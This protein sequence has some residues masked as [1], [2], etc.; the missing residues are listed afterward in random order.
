MISITRA[1]HIFFRRFLVSIFYLAVLF[2]VATTAEAATLQLSPNTGVY[3]AGGTFSTRVIVNTQG[4]PINAAEG[5]ISFNPDDL[6]VVSVSKAGSIFTLWTREP[7]FSNTSG[8][9]SFGGGSPSGYTGAAGTVMTVTFRVKHAGTTNVTYAAGSVL[10]ADGKGTNVISNMQ[11]GSYTVQAVT[12]AP[13]PEYVPPANTPNAPVITSTTHP[14]EDKWYAVTNAKLTWSVP[15]GVTAVRTLLDD[16]KTTVPTKVYDSPIR[17]VSLPD[18]PQGVSYFHIQFK[19]A[20]GW[21]RVTHYRLAVDTEKPTA[22]SVTEAEG[23]DVARPEKKLSLNIE[24]ATSGVGKF[25]IQIDGGEKVTFD[26]SKK[27][28]VYTTPALDPGNHSVIIEGFDAAGNSII[29]SYDFT[30]EAF[31]KPVFTEYPNEVASNII[32]VIRGTTRPDSSVFI[33]LEKI[34]TAGKE[35]EVKADA[36]GVFTFI[37]EGRFEEGVYEI[38]AFARDMNGAQSIESDTVRIA[39]QQPGYV[40]AGNAAVSV[41]SVVIPLIALCGLFIFVLWYGWQHARTVRAR[42]RK[43]LT[44]AEQ[45]LVR[46]FDGIVSDMKGGFESLKKARKGRLTKQEQDLLES[47]TEGFDAAERR[48]KKEMDDIESLVRK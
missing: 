4:Q 40:R 14:D 28:H 41:L 9:I 18:L 12:E 5:D 43:E 24:D 19:N 31:E 13:Q 26:D 30:I 23:N 38:H 8:K 25:E 44:E 39:V 35:Y 32:P 47:L 7:E 22:F 3:S 17:D 1:P 36:S 29:A 34:G 45:S 46:E 2:C 16:K 21:G 33:T 15:A 6:A 37:P 48:I 42:I 11:G 27:T 10:A 20:D